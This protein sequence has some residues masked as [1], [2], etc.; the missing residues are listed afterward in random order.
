MSAP[1]ISVVIPA[2]DEAESVHRLYHEIEQALSSLHVTW[3]VIFVD[4]GSEDDTFARV[5][6]LWARRPET[7]RGVRFPRNLGKS[8]ALRAGFDAARGGT[9][10]TMDGDLQDDPREIPRFLAALNE[11]YDLVSGWKRRRHDPLGK[12]IASKIFNG[13]VAPLAGLR[14]HDMNCGF[15]A[16]RAQLTRELP[17]R[18]GLHRFIP[19]L[20]HALGYRVGEIVVA[21]RP[22]SFGRSKYGW[23]R[24]PQALLDLTTVMLA[25]R[26]GRRPPRGLASPASYAVAERLD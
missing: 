23:K 4:D 26:F 18:S 3:E 16:Y 9:V 25:T 24:I 11:G 5:R 22:R 8:V 14:L 12:R 10:I 7:V 15:K 2:H 21:H 13:L 19:V 6:D 17:L 1:E 20:A